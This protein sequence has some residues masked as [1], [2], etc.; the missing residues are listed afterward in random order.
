MNA[1][2]ADSSMR[3][4]FELSVD[5]EEIKEVKT[6]D[7]I[8]VTLRLRRTD[9]TQPYTMYAMQDEICY[10]STFFE[11]VEKS[12]VLNEGIVAEDIAKVDRFREFY[13]NYLSMSGGMQW[14]EDALIGS[15]QLR[16]IGESGVTKISS[17]DYLVS[18]H[19][20]SDSY[21]CDANELMIILSTDCVIRFMTNGGSE[22]A[23]Q[24][25]QYG[26]KI[27]KPKTPIREGYVFEGW[28]KDIN[29]SEEWDFEND[30][31]Q[32]NMSLY[33]KWVVA[34]PVAETPNTSDGLIMTLWWLLLILI[35]ILLLCIKMMREK[36]KKTV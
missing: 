15:F 16:V 13:M 19:D 27:T 26:E 23:D 17:Q 5:G 29:L 3:F 30:V 25:V 35:L 12:A 9:S 21:A 24:T 31:V 32:K 14:N 6:G 1:S 2:A 11:I 34:E 20:G 28:Y 4:F 22:I 10:D 33:A 8:T 18:L 36:S 7:I